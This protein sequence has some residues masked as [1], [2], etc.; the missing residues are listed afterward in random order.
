VP[1]LQ[2][3]LPKYLQIAGHIRDQIV[4]GDLKP[5]DEI[6]SER[7][8]A[9]AWNV[10]RPTATKALETL[11]VQGLVESR[12]GSGTY[13]R[14]TPA[15]PRARERYDRA[16]DH[17]TMYSDAESVEFVGTEIV[18]DPPEHVREALRLATGSSAIRRAR[19]IKRDGHEPIELSV[20][21]FAGHLAESAPGLLVPERLRGGT[22]KYIAAMTGQNATYARDR[23][24]AR[25][26][27]D[28]EAKH[29]RLTHPAGVLIYQLTAFDP[30]DSPVQFDEATY[31]PE[32]WAFRQ[33]YPLD[34]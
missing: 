30:S 1:E 21:W 12:Q 32:R 27:T 10:A 5:G 16:R 34:S 28:D 8:L 6:S 18:D 3:V 24:A 7:A 20:S 15:A 31:P 9:S 11:R 25:L 29:L 26:A 33:E 23:V 2:E 14:G 17:G 19:V 4:R 22:C 13:V